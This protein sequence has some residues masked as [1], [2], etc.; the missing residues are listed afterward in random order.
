MTEGQSVDYLLAGK[1]GNAEVS[2]T[3][4]E[5]INLHTTSHRSIKGIAFQAYKQGIPTSVFIKYFLQIFA[6]KWKS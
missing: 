5:H 1:Y 3:W 2:C 6:F 4:R